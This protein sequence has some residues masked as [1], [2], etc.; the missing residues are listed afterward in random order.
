[1]KMVITRDAGG[2]VEL[3]PIGAFENLYKEDGDWVGSRHNS[4][5]STDDWYV[6]YLHFKGVC[7]LLG[8]V[9]RKGSKQVVDITV[10]RLKK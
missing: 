3:W 8:F 6:P 10:K 9:P 7:K 1:M 4:I 2:F 5:L